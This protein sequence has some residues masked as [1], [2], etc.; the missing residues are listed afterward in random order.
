MGEL[1]SEATK[2]DIHKTELLFGT[3]TQSDSRKVDTVFRVK[4]IV[5]ETTTMIEIGVNEHKPHH[6]SKPTLESKPAR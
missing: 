6:A 1:S 2:V 4:E 3:L 5:F